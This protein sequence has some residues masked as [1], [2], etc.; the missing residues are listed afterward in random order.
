MAIINKELLRVNINKMEFYNRNQQINV[1]L[2]KKILNKNNMYIS[3]N[4][5]ILQNFEN[6]LLDNL[7]IININHSKY[8]KVIE[9]NIIK[10]ITLEKQ[11]ALKFSELGDNK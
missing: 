6:N 11:T 4:L 1:D 5:K 9:K 7:K 3:T 10:Y 2:L 8:I